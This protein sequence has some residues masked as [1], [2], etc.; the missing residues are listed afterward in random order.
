MIRKVLAV[1]CISLFVCV[2]LAAPR[3]FVLAQTAEPELAADETDIPPITPQPDV[4]EP[5]PQP[6]VAPPIEPGPVVSVPTHDTTVMGGINLL[7]EFLGLGSTDPRMIVASLIRVALG[8]LG[9]IFVVMIL[10][11]GFTF[12]TAGGNSE[13][14]GAAKRTFF[15]AI[16]GL[17]IILSAQSI[18]VYVVKA[19]NGALEN[20]VPLISAPPSTPPAL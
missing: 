14:T 16:I 18:V 11:S 4:A 3:F 20:D 6:T 10:L 15:N 8:F 19:F 7:G 2:G 12:L 13:R 9:I 1:I 5:Q 17:V